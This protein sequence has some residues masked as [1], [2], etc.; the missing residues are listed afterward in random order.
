MRNY[1]SLIFDLDGT[2]VDTDELIVNSFVR[3][4]EVFPPKIGYKREDLYSYSGP[5]LK[6]SLKNHYEEKDIE[7]A[8][9]IFR[10][11][12]Q[13]LIDSSISMYPYALE[14]L[15]ELKNKGYR[16]AINTNRNEK[17]TIRILENLGIKNLFEVV[18][19]PDMLAH[20]KPDPEGCLQVI[21]TLG[22]S[23][24]ECLFIGDNQADFYTARNAGID[25]LLVSWSPRKRNDDV[26]P[27]FNMDSFKELV[28]IIENGK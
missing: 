4:F 9:K 5:L 17:L 6:D 3:L 26:K 21:S 23:K 19:C 7:E 20:E 1:S 24:E 22:V 27:K 14:S 25:C 11:E 16:L 13:V 8:I 28:G 12:T 10:R 15:N 2:L 18:V